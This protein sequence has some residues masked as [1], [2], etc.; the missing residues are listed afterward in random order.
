VASEEAQDEKEL[1]SWI[2]VVETSIN[3]ETADKILQQ[4]EDD[5]F[6]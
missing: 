2:F 1:I 4:L 5:S 6:F 3:G